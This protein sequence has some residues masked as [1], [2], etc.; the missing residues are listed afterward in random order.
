VG[1]VAEEKDDEIVLTAE[2]ERY[3]DHV[4][5]TDED[6]DKRGMQCDLSEDEVDEAE[7]RS[8][9]DALLQDNERA[10]DNASEGKDSGKEPSKRLFR[11]GVRAAAAA[12]GLGCSKP[13]DDKEGKGADTDTKEREKE[14]QGP[15]IHMKSYSKKGKKK[16]RSRKAG[17]KSKRR[18]IDDDDSAD[19]DQEFEVPLTMVVNEDFQSVVKT[20]GLLKGRS[21]GTGMVS[22]LKKSF[23][24]CIYRMVYFS[25]PIHSLLSLFADYFADL[26]VMS[27]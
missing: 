5:M 9:L 17:G 21:S 1:D 18:R 12:L 6:Y 26:P 23:V 11:I 16:E 7:V 20:A 14:P 15:V 25:F 10:S 8:E 22:I 2:Y 19:V 24:C 27:I 13:E 4:D 3:N